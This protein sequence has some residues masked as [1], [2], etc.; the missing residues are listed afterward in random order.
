[1]AWGSSQLYEAEG[2]SLS[3]FAGVDAKT[4]LCTLSY[5][6]GMVVPQAEGQLSCHPKTMHGGF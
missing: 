6:E 5:P 1:M 4:I 3:F 2:Y